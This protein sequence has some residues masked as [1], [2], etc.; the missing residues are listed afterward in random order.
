[1]TVLFQPITREQQV[2]VSREVLLEWL[3]HQRIS[4]TKPFKVS[5]RNE[6]RE[7]FYNTAPCFG[8]LQ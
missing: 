8:S 4:S 5:L 1:M 7:R 3:L 6:K 2:A